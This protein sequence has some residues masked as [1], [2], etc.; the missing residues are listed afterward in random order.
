MLVFASV[1]MVPLEGTGSGRFTRLA[2]GVD[3]GHRF[4]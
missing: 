4:H 2:I 3:N 1:A